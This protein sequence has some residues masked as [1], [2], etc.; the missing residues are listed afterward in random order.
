M[1]YTAK[2]PEGRRIRIYDPRNNTMLPAVGAV[3]TTEGWL[4]TWIVG[5][6]P[7]EGGSR[8]VLVDRK[9]KETA[10]ARVHTDFDVRDKESGKTLH[11]VRWSLGKDPQ[12]RD[13]GP[14]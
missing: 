9:K 3:D 7:Q 10:S 2:T 1:I 12:P 8:R 14:A 6:P 4:E 11:R 13:L 5:E